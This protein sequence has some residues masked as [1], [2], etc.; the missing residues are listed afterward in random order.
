M[1]FNGKTIKGVLLDISGVLTESTTEGSEAINGSVD[2]VNK[3]QDSG[4]Q[5]RLVTNETQKTREDIFNSLRGH[6][7]VIEREQIFPP[8]LAMVKLMKDKGLRPHLLVHP[9]SLPDF[10]DIDTKNPNCVILGDAVNEFTY[11]SLNQAFKVLIKSDLVELYSL[12]KG[13]YYKEDDELTLDVGPFTAALEFATGRKATVVG[14]PSKDFF[15]TAVGDMGLSPGETVMV[16]DDVVSDVGGA[17]ECG[18]Q[19][20]L[21]RTGKFRPS[22][23]AHPQVKP[24]RIVDNLLHFA[25]I[26]LAAN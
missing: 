25:Q 13:R 11:N 24:D 17:Q 8:A 5:V 20:V 3:I 18:L 2:A 1:T 12:G 26:L 15:L 21:V 16:G 6:G 4:I 19:G 10:C 14:K 22:D 9:K 7:F 23:E